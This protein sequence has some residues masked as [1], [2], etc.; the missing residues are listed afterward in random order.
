MWSGVVVSAGD[1]STWIP[2]V[3]MDPYCR[4]GSLLSLW[5]PIV[6]MVPYCPPYCPYGSL[7]SWIHFVL[8]P[9]C[10]GSI[11]SWIHFVLDPFCPGSILSWFHFV[12]V[13]FCPWSLLSWIRPL[14]TGQGGRPWQGN[15]GQGHWRWNG[16]GKEPHF[17]PTG[18]KLWK[19]QTKNCK[20]I[21]NWR[22]W[23]EVGPN[24]LWTRAIAMKFY[25]TS[26]GKDKYTQI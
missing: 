18:Q 26:P 10:P 20:K 9:F 21:K 11:L 16:I 23:V 13:P 17:Q 15:I 8:V 5:F 2:I 14:K 12:L 19:N 25:F 22:F 24:W 6:P 7:M 3:P 4:Y 1:F